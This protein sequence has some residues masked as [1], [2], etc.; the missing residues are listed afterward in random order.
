MV[1]GGSPGRMKSFAEHLAPILSIPVEDVEDIHRTD[2]YSF[3]KVGPVLSISV[4][5]PFDKPTSAINLIIIP[6]GFYLSEKNT[7]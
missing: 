5:L 4:S 7:S 1:T 2:R 6:L 3:F